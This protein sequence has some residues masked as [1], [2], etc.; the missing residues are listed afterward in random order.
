MRKNGNWIG[1]RRAKKL[2]ISDFPFRVRR[3]SPCRRP[4]AVLFTVDQRRA[5]RDFRSN[6][7]KYGI[8][9]QLC[10]FVELRAIVA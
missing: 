3:F 5:D 10:I 7:Q 8:F 4:G 6:L 2:R 9:M 1:G